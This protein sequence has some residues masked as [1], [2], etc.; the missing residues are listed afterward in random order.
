MDTILQQ[1]NQQV[2]NQCTRRLP[3]REIVQDAEY[4]M[5]QLAHGP[6]INKVR[7]GLQLRRVVIVASS[8]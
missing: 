3:V 7:S 1:T 2:D 4:S 8:G 6:I 5:L